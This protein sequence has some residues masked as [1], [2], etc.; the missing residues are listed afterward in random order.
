MRLKERE[1]ERDTGRE[2]EDRMTYTTYDTS[3]IL[4]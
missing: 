2:S 4:Y 1:R 3:C